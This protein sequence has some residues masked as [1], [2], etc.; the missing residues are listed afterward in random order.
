MTLV[1]DENSE[2]PGVPTFYMN[3]YGMNT[4]ISAPYF[5]LDFTSDWSLVW[6]AN[7]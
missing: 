7:C 2:K 4:S 1:L 6:A 5:L 3:V